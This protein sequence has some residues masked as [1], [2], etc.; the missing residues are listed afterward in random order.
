MLPL[1]LCAAA[2]KA[3]GSPPATDVFLAPLSMRAGLPTIGT[4][5]PI[6][7]WR[8]YDNQPSFTPDGRSILY[9]SVREDEQADIYRY[10][11]TTRRATRVTRTNPESEY[12]AVVMPGGKRFSV[13]RVERDS[14]QRLWSF[15]LDGSA[16]RVVIEQLKPVGYYAWVDAT[17]V[18]TFVL[19]RPNALVV[20]DLT[21]GRADTLA[22]NIGRSIARLP[23]GGGFSYVQLRDSTATLTAVRGGHASDLIAL[24]RGA[25]DVA[26]LP[27]GGVLASS[28]AKIYAWTPGDA[29]WAVAA[30]LASRGL[31]NVTRM[32]VS[33]DG[34]AIAI[35]AE[36]R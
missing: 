6:T 35:V 10:D 4:P 27:S 25:E 13:V 23:D 2:A 26:W 5:A 14:T 30:D 29:G 15:A 12:S 3:Q 8:G 31:S 19:G 17:H 9:T 21:T 16:P 7:S 22:R 18:A 34:R 28:G 24:P 11:R 36:R 33:P 20:V 32:A 1:V